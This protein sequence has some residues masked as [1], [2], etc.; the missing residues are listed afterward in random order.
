MRVQYC[1]HVPF[2][3]P[4]AI[5]TWATERGHELS[6]THLFE[7]QSFPEP[8]AIDLLVV[9]G[10][11]MG[12]GDDQDW[13]ER[14]RD[15]IRGV[16]ETGGA[17][18]GVCLGAQQLAAALG[19]DV[20]PHEVTEIGWYPV[21]ATDAASE[22][23][24][25]E[26]PATYTPLSWH[27]D[28]FDVP[29]GAT[30]TATSEACRNQAFVAAEGRAVGVQFHLEATPDSVAELVAASDL[31]DGEWVQSPER[32]LAGGDY[33]ALHDHLGSLLDRLV[34]TDRRE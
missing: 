21:K 26:L 10:G 5:E 14:E 9:M 17:V 32:L 15:V 8:D 13:L 16:L 29:D 22:T 19:A 7:G 6:G 27:G 18:F 12:V 31:S 3:P 20:Y 23:V 1:Q 2:E 34:A 28:T 24:F 25:A 11:P 33:A 4:A 30:L